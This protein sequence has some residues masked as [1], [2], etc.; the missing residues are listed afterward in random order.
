[1]C[2]KMSSIGQSM[3]NFPDNCVTLEASKNASL[4]MIYGF[5]NISR[6]NFLIW[7]NKVNVCSA[8]NRLICIIFIFLCGIF[9][10]T[11]GNKITQNEMAS[12]AKLNFNYLKRKHFE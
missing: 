10:V 4:K 12:K 1:M 6:L 9:N 7:L 8:R 11:D 2:I 3:L 5:S